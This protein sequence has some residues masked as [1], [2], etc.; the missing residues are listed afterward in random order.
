MGAGRWGQIGERVAHLEYSH[1]WNLQMI[2][3]N[4]LIPNSVAYV[5][6]FLFSSIPLLLPYDATSRMVARHYC[7]CDSRT[8][9]RP[10]FTDP[11]SATASVI[12]TVRVGS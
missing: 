9:R 1:D 5:A 7:T 11:F 2:G 8:Q 10:L 3:S 6:R 12:K 4:Q